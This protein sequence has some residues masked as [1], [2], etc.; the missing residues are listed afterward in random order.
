M[1][2]LFIGLIL[3]AR[4]NNKAV[5][6]TANDQK[7]LATNCRNIV[8]VTTKINKFVS[9]RQVQ[10]VRTALRAPRT[11]TGRFKRAVP[12]NVH[13]TGDIAA[14]TAEAAREQVPQ[15]VRKDFARRESDLSAGNPKDF[16]L[17]GVD[18]CIL[19]LTKND[20]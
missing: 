2:F 3:A 5:L 16:T 18:L 4:G 19:P 14:H 12:E 15:V 6:L 20:V 11:N 13:Q 17:C 8:I 7:S 1:P 10:G 9:K